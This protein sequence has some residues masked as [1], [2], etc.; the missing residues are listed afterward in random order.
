MTNEELVNNVVCKNCRVFKST[1]KPCNMFDKDYCFIYNI[2]LQVA[3]EKDRQLQK[4]V[5]D[6]VKSFDND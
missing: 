6:A 2:A 4:Y 3:N 5:G 1:I